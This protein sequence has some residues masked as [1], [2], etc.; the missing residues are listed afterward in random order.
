MLGDCA[1]RH[2]A[3][4]RSQPRPARRARTSSNVPPC[5]RRPCAAAMHAQAFERQ[6][7]LLSRELS[8][9]MGA[10]EGLGRDR[11]AL[12]EHLRAAEQARPRV[13]PR[14]CPSPRAAPQPRARGGPPRPPAQAGAASSQR[15]PGEPPV[16]TVSHD[17]VTV[18][19]AL[20]YR[21]GALP[22]ACTQHL[23][24][25]PALRLGR[26]APRCATPRSASA[27][28]CSGAWRP[29]RPRCA[30]RR[31][32]SP[33]RSTSARRARRPAPALRSRAAFM[34]VRQSCSFRRPGTAMSATV[35]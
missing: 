13:Y 16:M 26:R 28:A 24:S 30:P 11:L 18:R 4:A 23:L 33:R 12:Q 35:S 31:A 29:R 2:A 8:A 14:A 20:S 3:R 34:P 27:R 6:V 17:R 5:Q 7:D 19:S 25:S 1:S 32:A 22:R 21:A 15:A 9:N 10:A